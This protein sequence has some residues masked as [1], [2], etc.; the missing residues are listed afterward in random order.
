MSFVRLFGLVLLGL[1][2]GCSAGTVSNP[3]GSDQ[4]ASDAGTDAGDVDT[5]DGDGAIDDGDGGQDG[6]DPAPDG[7]DPADDGGLDGGD[8]TADGGDAGQV[9]TLQVTDQVVTA[10]II[11]FGINLGSDN[12]WDSVLTKNRIKNGG[13]EGTLFRHL[14]R[15]PGG[16]AT[17]FYDWNDYTYT[18]SAGD[19]ELSGRTWLDTVVGANA[20][21]LA[22]DR[23]WQADVIDHVEHAV[24]PGREEEGERLR[25]VFASSG[26]AVGADDGGQ[27]NEVGML[28]EKVEDEVGYVGQHG[29]P[30]WAFTTGGA[31]IL[32]ST[33]DQPPGTTG[34]IVAVIEA[35]AQGDSATLMYPMF[36]TSRAAPD[37]T[38]RVSFWAKG[39]GQLSLAYGG[40]GNPQ[41]PTPV[42]LT[43]QWQY[44]SDVAVLVSGFSED[45]TL[46]LH[47]IATGGTVRL[48]DISAYK[49]GHTNPTAFRDQVVAALELLQP[50]SLRHLAIGGNSVDNLLKPDHERMAYAYRREVPPDPA[51]DWPGH[52]NTNG[53]AEIHSY[54]LHEFLQLCEHL[55][56]QPWY[57]VPGTLLP[58][59][60][61]DLMEYLAGPDDSPYGQIRAQRGHPQ[62]WTEVFDQIHIEIGNEA[63]NW[64]PAYAYGGWNGPEYWTTLF[65][66][67]KAKLAGYPGAADRVAFQIGAQNYNT[68]LGTSLVAYHGQAGDSYAIAPYV[69][70]EMTNAQAAFGDEELFSWL[71]GWVWHLNTN[72]PMQS[73]ADM[74]AQSQSPDLDIGIYEVNHHIT[75]GDAPVE[76]RNRAVTSLGGALNVINHMLLMLERYDVRVQNFFS[77]IQES[78]NGIGL[79]GSLLSTKTGQERYRP[80][81]LGLVMVNHVLAGDLV[82]VTRGGAD[83][84]WTSSFDYDGAP[85][86]LQVPFLHAYATRDGDQR[87]L[88][89]L[90]L[91][92]TDAL[93]VQIGLPAPA[94]G[95]SATRWQL[96]GD[97]IAADNELAHPAQVQIL[98]DTLAGFGDGTTLQL[99]AHSMTVLRWQQ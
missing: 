88:I 45:D 83:P 48:D 39:D 36:Q 87:G 4:D 59:E 86:S 31:R 35:P 32:T 18:P 27:L 68:W 65:E 53:S 50:G 70:H 42:A 17:S 78:Y 94:Q 34:K 46:S 76:P 16:D 25:F 41:N 96:V 21:V 90:N 22:G 55:G 6:G 14:A 8:E 85:V 19:D 95:D 12:F 64:A 7:G 11:R 28:I 57:C 29:G 47:F 99:P 26:P 98:E 79:W 43:D 13:F 60:M 30:L 37:G 63:W 15:G 20:W 24:F 38:F 9:T 23:A 10:G 69:I 67:A 92:R 82:A 49:E 72:G 97:S 33:A 52:P 3:D 93:P 62:P 58:H 56:A 73:V 91:H 2:V 75:G 84:G 5:D 1:V 77:L 40:W 51:V 61:E 54:G 71:F 66:R 81:F 89:L 74:I 80:T 44:F